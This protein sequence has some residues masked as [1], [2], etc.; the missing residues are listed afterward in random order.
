MKNYP[1][2]VVD[3]FTQIYAVAKKDSKVNASR[4]YG[5]FSQMGAYIDF[6]STKIRKHFNPEYI[7]EVFEVQEVVFD[8]VKLKEIMIERLKESGV[9]VIYNKEVERVLKNEDKIDV[10]VF[11]SDSYTATHVINTT[12]SEINKILERSNLEKISLKHELIEMAIVELPEP[13]RNM[14]VTIMDGPFFSLM[15]YPPSKYHTFSHVRYTPHCSW[16]DLEGTK[17]GVSELKNLESNFPYM[18]RDGIRYMPILKDCIHKESIY[19]VKTIL[20]GN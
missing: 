4:F 14:C 8:P 16:N 13:I 5:T 7:E 18:I 11:N 12:Y 3:N 9:K 1:E 6:A 15:P 20:N 17:D 19:V 2:I 10:H